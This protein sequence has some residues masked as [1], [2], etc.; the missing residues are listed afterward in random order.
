MGEVTIRLSDPRTDE[1]VISE[2]MKIEEDVFPPEYRGEYESI[3]ARFR[4]NRE[5]F[6]LA[7]EGGRIVGSLCFFPI[8]ERLHSEMLREPVFHDDDILPEDVMAFGERNHIYLLSV[9]LYKS[10]Q[11]RGIGSMM[12]DACFNALRDR[13]LRGQETADILASVV[14]EQ[15]RRLVEKY[16]FSLART[17]TEKERFLLYRREGAL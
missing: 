5:M 12:M 1:N 7:R 8:S 3:R 6:V 14:S 4:K 11:G 10:C 15:G 2:L 16:G 9:A 13:R 17:P